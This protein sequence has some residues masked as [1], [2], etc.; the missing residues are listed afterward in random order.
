[1]SYRSVWFPG[2]LQSPVKRSR[3]YGVLNEPYE[4]LKM[5]GHGAQSIDIAASLKLFSSKEAEST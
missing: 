1:M 4:I 5:L 2:M 3:I